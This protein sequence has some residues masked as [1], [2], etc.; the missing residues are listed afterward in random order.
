MKPFQDKEATVIK[1][2]G[3][4]IKHCRDHYGMTQ[5]ELGTRMGKGQNAISVYES[6]QR[7]PDIVSLTDLAIALN[8]KGDSVYRFLML[9][10]DYYKGDYH[11]G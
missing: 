7:L 1:T 11:H 2:P 3:E 6:D 10:R 5:A 8:W 9:A 4:M